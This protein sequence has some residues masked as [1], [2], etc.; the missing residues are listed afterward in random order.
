[1]TFRAKIHRGAA[2]VGGTCV[3]LEAGGQRLL[4]DLGMPLEAQE[5]EVPLPDVL[6]LREQDPS[7]LGVVVSHL[8][9]DHCGLVPYAV[10]EVLLAMGLGAAH[11]LRKAEFFTGRPPLPEPRWPLQDR[12]P[13]EVGPFRVTPYQVEHSAL[14]A[15][16]L[17]VEAEGRRLFYT[18][19]FRAHGNDR[20][21]WRRLLADPPRDVHAMLMEGTQIGDGRVGEG[22]SELD[23]RG[24]LARRFR[25]WPGLV[26][27]SWSSQNLDRLLTIYD[28]AR[29]AGR[30]LVVDLYTATLA[31][32]A[33][34]P[35]IPVPGVDG[36]EVYCRRRERLQVRD[37]GEFERT[38]GVN[39]VRIFPEDLAPRAREL[40]LMLRPSMARE[41]EQARVLPG[42]LA[43]WSMWRG[44]LDGPTER[45]L[46]EVLTRHGV[47]IEVHHV[48]G[49]AYVTDLRR[50]VDAV[51]PVRVI[52]IHTSNP[53]RYAATFSQTE[54]WLDGA[55]SI[56]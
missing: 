22:P 12:Q 49:H 36:L 25:S 42:A 21:P 54:S 2:Q 31:S 6:G 3:E 29:E 33:G 14:D 5:G 45:R 18:G 23:L 48:S 15:F 55:W 20:D 4:L 32:A 13:F 11:I 30:T 10:P 28:A 24:A 26:L 19:D 46:Q 27:A 40:V 9:G 17:L 44:Y 35:G 56:V 38:R 43:V 52:P 53:Q 50:L 47:S 39:K 7:L 16:A 51:R 34:L 1:M 41:L 8:H 37:A